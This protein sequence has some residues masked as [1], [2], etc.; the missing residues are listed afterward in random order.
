MKVWACLLSVLYAQ[1]L[2]GSDQKRVDVVNITA[3]EAG[4][5]TIP[6]TFSR[7][8]G[9]EEE[10]RTYNAKVNGVILL[11][12]SIKVE[13]ELS[14]DQSYQQFAQ[15][16]CPPAYLP[17]GSLTF[18]AGRHISVDLGTGSLSSKA[19]TKIELARVPDDGTEIAEIVKTVRCN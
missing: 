11:T 19:V 14:A 12:S 8:D 13:V 5:F 1:A 10:Q 16:Y 4:T 18:N 7:G 17:T 15:Q 6:A 3:M 2:Y 9:S